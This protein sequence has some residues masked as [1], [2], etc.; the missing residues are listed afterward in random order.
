MGP[1]KTWTIIYGTI[2]RAAV[3]LKLIAPQTLFIYPSLP[4]VNLNWIGLSKTAE[5][6]I[7]N[8]ADAEKYLQYVD[9]TP[10]THI[11][12]V[13]YEMGN[14]SG[15]ELCVDSRS[16]DG[17]LWGDRQCSYPDHAPICE[18]NCGNINN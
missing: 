8:S 9:G 18:F 17:T 7:T 11:P 1:V 6:K 4:P 10:Y 2:K 12:G 5:V 15:N 14:E 3:Y 16:T 13:S